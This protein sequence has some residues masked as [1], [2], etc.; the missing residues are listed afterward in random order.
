MAVCGPGGHKIVKTRLY[1]TT[2]EEEEEEEEDAEEESEEE[3]EEEGIP[4]RGCR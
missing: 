1:G 3:E 2:M 4:Y